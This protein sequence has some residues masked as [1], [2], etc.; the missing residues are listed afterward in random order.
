MLYHYANIFVDLFQSKSAI[1]AST[2]TA[3]TEV[4]FLQNC[5]NI[6][7]KMA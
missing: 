1:I 7:L 2:N 5:N 4:F 3:K 6:I